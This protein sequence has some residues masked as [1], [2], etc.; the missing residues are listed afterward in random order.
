LAASEIKSFRDLDVWREAIELVVD[1]YRLT[2]TFP[3]SER[4]GLASQL[5]RSAT[6][7]PANIAEGH[8]RR[9][10][11]AYLNHVNIALG[12]E[13]EFATHLYVSLRLGFCSQDQVRLLSERRERIGRMLNALSTSLKRRNAVQFGLSLSCVIAFF[14]A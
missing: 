8:S 7:I 9:S 6:S 1:C 13:A 4:Y 5:R 3:P 11:R 14:F 10:R 2:D 12:S